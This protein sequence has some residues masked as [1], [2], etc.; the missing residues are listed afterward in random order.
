MPVATIQTN[1]T[2]GE[3]SPRLGGRVDLAKYDNGLEVLRNMYAHP[4]GG[5]A[6][7][8][9]F[10][11]IR[12]VLGR[13]RIEGP[14]FSAPEAWDAGAGWSL[15]AEGAVRQSG[16]SGS[17]DLKQ[18]EVLVPG[19]FHELRIEVQSVDSGR[20]RPEMGA[21]CF[22]EWIDRPGTHVLKLEANGA[23]AHFRLQAE[24]GFA[25]RIGRIEIREIG[26][27]ARL[28][29]FQF[30]TEQAYVL[31]LSD[32]QMRVYKDGGVVLDGD[33]PVEVQTPVSYT[34]LTLPTN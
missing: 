19:R 8:S 2:A 6:R 13:Q 14:D 10:R 15:D 33:D 32:K 26:P 23:D 34:H 7:R 12:E 17:S 22:G 24:A 27:K 20:V 3:I 5:A 18:E 16:Q 1:F 11:F 25:G 31:E 9:G 4:H 28:V 21:G 30:S 29:P